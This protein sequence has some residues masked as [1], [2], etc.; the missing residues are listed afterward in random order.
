MKRI[1]LFGGA[2]AASALALGLGV[3]TAGAAELTHGVNYGSGNNY[4]PGEWTIASLPGL[5]EGLRAHVYQQPAGAP[6]GNVYDIA[7]GQVASFDFAIDPDTGR[8]VIPLSGASITITN[9][10][11]GSATFNPF[12]LTDN[13]STALG[14]INNS[15]R[16]NFG[17]LNGSPTFNVGNINYNAGVNSTFDVVLHVAETGG[18]T[19][20]DHIVINEGSGFAGGVPEPASWALMIV[21]FGAAGAMLRRQKLQAV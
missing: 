18:G 21:G 3:T 5:E 17:F 2:I 13:G 1:F 8:S 16:L 6:T 4:M 10:A 20:N 11:G 14:D 19:L 9:R 7:L 15:E 12:A